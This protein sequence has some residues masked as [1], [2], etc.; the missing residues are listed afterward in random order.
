MKTLDYQNNLARLIHRH[1]DG[2]DQ[3]ETY[4]EDANALLVPSGQQI[5]VSRRDVRPLTQK[6]RRYVQADL[7][8]RTVSGAVILE[9]VLV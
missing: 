4:K 7:G 1:S 6:R 3:I 9:V 2:T 5:R 8:K